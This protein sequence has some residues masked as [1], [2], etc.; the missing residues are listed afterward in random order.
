M[1]TK[2]KRARDIEYSGSVLPMIEGGYRMKIASD[3]DAV[4]FTLLRQT[5]EMRLGKRIESAPEYLVQ[6]V[7]NAERHAGSAFGLAPVARE[8]PNDYLTILKA[9]GLS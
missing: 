3:F 2:E 9:F 8:L 4:F 7:P 6:V 1:P 5:S